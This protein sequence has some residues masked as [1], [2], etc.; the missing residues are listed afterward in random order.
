MKK[1][2]LFVII[3]LFII[4]YT[5]VFRKYEIPLRKNTCNYMCQKEKYNKLEKKGIL[6]DKL[7]VKNYL[8]E[9]FPH[10]NYAKT[11]FSTKIPED[12]E[13]VDYPPNFV[14][15]NSGGSRMFKIVKN[16]NFKV[17]ELKKLGSYYLSIDFS[18]YGYRKIPFLG[19]EEPQYKYNDKKIFIEEY[20]PHIKEFR[21][22][23]VKGEILYY[24]ILKEEIN[25][26]ERVD[27]DWKKMKVFS[28][29]KDVTLKSE[30]PNNINKIID[31]C[32]EFYDKEKIDFVRIDFILSGENFYFGEFT[33]TPT[34]CREKYSN[35]FENK[36][37]KLF[38]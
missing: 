29:D 17:D 9:N 18:S 5:E 16:N 34:N 3:I 24:E 35:N 22:L 13:K 31:F 4:L 15:K 21:V 36:F 30:P 23:M 38:I 2:I 14:F 37:K 27:K 6:S 20:I 28:W 8:D 19:L 12:L 1:I 26:N 7:L 10:I 32:K 11:L 33:F 25:L